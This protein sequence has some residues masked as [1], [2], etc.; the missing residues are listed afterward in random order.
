M[1]RPNPICPVCPTVPVDMHPLRVSYQHIRRHLEQRE[2][3]NAIKAH[4]GIKAR[5]IKRQKRDN[6]R[7]HI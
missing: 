7:D 6:E 1:K 2:A 3:S 4:A 5:R